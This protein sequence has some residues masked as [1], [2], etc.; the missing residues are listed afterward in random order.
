MLGNLPLSHSRNIHTCPM[1]EIGSLTHP[2]FDVL[3]HLL[4]SK[5]DFRFQMAEISRVWIFSKITYFYTSYIFTKVPTMN[6][7][8]FTKF[9]SL[10]P[11][12]MTLAFGFRDS[13]DTL[14][15][16]PG[17]LPLIIITSN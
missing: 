9:S 8:Y 5:V 1:E 7:L 4:L 13:K 2:P 12:I 15:S 3:V 6:V 11:I 17:T 16:S 14:I 10:V